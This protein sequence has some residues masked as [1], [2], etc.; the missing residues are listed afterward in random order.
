MKKN[1]EII[2]EASISWQVSSSYR[3]DIDNLPQFLK[4]MADEFQILNT[5]MEKKFDI[6]IPGTIVG[7][8]F[9][10]II[11]LKADK[12]YPGIVLHESLHAYDDNAKKEGRMSDTFEFKEA[13][14]LDF[15]R[16]PFDPM[17]SVNEAEAF[18][19]CALVYLEEKDKLKQICPNIYQYFVDYAFK[20]VI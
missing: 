15:T 6:A 1:G 11:Y 16:I 9:K 10:D 8:Y 5:S 20:D 18:V 4:G 13:Y 7:V 12:Y 19:E 3:K 2:E 14:G 17:N